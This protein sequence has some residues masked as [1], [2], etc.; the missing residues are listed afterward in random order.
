MKVKVF[1]FVFNRPDILSYQIKSLKKFLKNDFEM[2]VVYDTRDNQYYG[3]FKQTCEEEQVNFYHHISQPGQTPSFYNAQA[4]QW[5]YDNIISQEEDDCIVMILDHDIFL[6]DELDIVNQMKSYDII[7]CLQT[8]N[9][10]KY[11][12]PGLCVF[13][14]SSVQNIEFDFY[15]QVVDGEMLDNGGGTYKILSNKEIKFYDTG[16]EYPDEYDGI[17][18]TDDI[19]GGFGYEL[20]FNQKF[21]HFRNASNW[22]RQYS[23]GDV[24]KTDLLFKILSDIIH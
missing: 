11:V 8:R 21:L 4:I 18:I 23:V 7:G 12:W 24:K 6:I 15:P 2:N 16:V 19:T 13:K 17:N 10:I 3:Q 5:S 1:S 20:H 14:K 22:H 9:R